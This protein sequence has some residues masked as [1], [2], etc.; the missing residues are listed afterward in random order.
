MLLQKTAT[1]TYAE[2]RR[3]QKHM[4]A[5]IYHIIIAPMQWNFNQNAIF[6]SLCSF[7][8]SLANFLQG[9]FTILWIIT[10]PDPFSF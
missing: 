4:G 3:R 5:N 6:F 1:A 2:N 7:G 8:K 9:T 10:A